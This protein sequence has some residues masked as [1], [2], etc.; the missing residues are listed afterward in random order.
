MF[1]LKFEILSSLSISASLLKSV[2]KKLT[3]DHKYYKKSHK[4]S[5]EKGADDPTVKWLFFALMTFMDTPPSFA[6][7]R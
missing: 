4:N 3:D 6:S 5:T 7:Q 1:K 2:G